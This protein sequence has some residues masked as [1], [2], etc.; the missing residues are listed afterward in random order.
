MSPAGVKGHITCKRI[1]SGTW[2][3]RVLAAVVDVRCADVR[4]WPAREGEEAV[5]MMHGH[6]VGLAIVSGKPA[7]QS[8]HSPLPERSAAKLECSG[9]LVERRARTGGKQGRKARAEAESERACHQAMERIRKV[10]R[11]QEEGGGSPRS[12]TIFSIRT[13]SNGRSSNSRRTLHPAW[14][15]CVEDTGRPRGKREDLQDRVQRGA[16]SGVAETAR[17]HIS[18]PDGRPAHARG[19]AAWRTSRPKA[20]VKLLERDLRG[21]LLGISYGF[22]PGRSTHDA[23]DALCVRDR[24]QEG[25]L[26]T[27]RP[28]SDHSSTNQKD[29]LIRVLEHRIGDRRSSA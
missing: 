24:Q 19:F 1:A 6:E 16:L 11:E 20:V 3:V 10:A 18:K 25:E 17:V 21:R 26:H 8:G 4:P 12:S 2:E 7:K 29:W 9:E 5:A 13:A 23:L 22:R 15:G 14:I 27:V 28:E